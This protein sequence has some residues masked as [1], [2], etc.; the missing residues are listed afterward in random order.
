MSISEEHFKIMKKKILFLV[1]VFVCAAFLSPMCSD[2]ACG[3]EQGSK[4]LKEQIELLKKKLEMQQ[5]IDALNKKLKE[6]EKEKKKSEKAVKKEIKKA[7]VRR[8]KYRQKQ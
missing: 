2:T 1:S 5:Q 6:G 7:D 3:D 8:K 4:D